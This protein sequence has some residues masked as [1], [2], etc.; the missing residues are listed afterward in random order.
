M[1]KHYK[2]FVAA[3][4]LLIAS[5]A[6][7][8]PPA[9]TAPAPKHP[10][11][12]IGAQAPDF[13]L[14]ATDGKTYTLEDFKSAKI[15][16]ICFTCNHCA[17]AQAYEDRLM[18]LQKDYADKGVTVVAI[19]PNDPLALRIDELCFSDVSDSLDEMKIRAKDKNFNFP[20]LYDGETQTASAAYG[21][22]ATPHVFIFDADRKLRYQ[23]R[24]DNGEIKTPTSLD[25]RNALDALVAGKPVT[26]AT[27]R[28]FGCSIKWSDKR[29]AAVASL[30]KWDKEP[31]TLEMI[32]APAIATLAKN[33]S[34]NLR[35]I[36]I[37]ATWCGP[38]VAEM[39]D[40]VFINRMFRP[41]EFEFITISGDELSQ[42]DRALAFLTKEHVSSKNYLY[43]NA[44]KDKLAEALDPK[45]TGV[46]PYTV[47]I[48]PGGQIIY[49]HD[50]ALD[51]LELKHA[52]V[53]YLGRTAA[54][55]AGK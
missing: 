3:L 14:P 1:I 54:G 9:T 10:T 45:W 17:T 28:V 22:I 51:I 15:L 26:T 29:S 7:A 27:T 24:I 6:H 42:K 43:N 4:A 23:G 50:G 21:P 13:K 53:D 46:F 16:L 35:L 52:I 11:L 40:L 34:K 32:E 12:A 31:V 38:C 39:P 48:A 33:D 25:T 55:R 18:Q 49:R 20:Y 5:I 36:N 2:Y 37:W 41:R 44:D 19:C 47:L 8:A 30:A